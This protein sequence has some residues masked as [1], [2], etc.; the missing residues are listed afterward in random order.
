MEMHDYWTTQMWVMYAMPNIITFL[1]YMWIP[2]K[3]ARIRDQEPLEID[4]KDDVFARHST[5]LFQ[6]F[7]IACGVHHLTMPW[8][9]WEGWFW[10]LIIVDSIMAVISIGAATK[11]KL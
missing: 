9:M 4:A 10:P 3:M 5:L 7:I 6:L 8:F 2:I 1:A 11:L